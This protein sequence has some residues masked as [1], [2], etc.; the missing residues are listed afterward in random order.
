VYLPSLLDWEDRMSMAVS[1]ESRVPLLDYRIV[2]FLATVPIEQ[3][4]RNMQPKHL[5]KQIASSLL[6]QQV[7]DRR[8]KFNFSVPGRMIHSQSMSELAKDILLSPGSLSRGIFKP[9]VLRDACADI[10][11]RQTWMIVNMELWFKIFIDRDP[12]WV[13]KA[14]G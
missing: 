5:L 7:L 4:V 10:H 1:L 8:Q 14:K 3:K 12:Y 13:N 2:E 6:P 11:I 9:R